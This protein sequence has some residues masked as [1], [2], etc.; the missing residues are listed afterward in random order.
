[1]P[2]IF[3]LDHMDNRWCIKAC[4]QQ[5][6]AALASKLQELSELTWRQIRC[7]P[8]HG[9]GSEKLSWDTIRPAKSEKIPKDA[10]FLAFRFHGLKAMV[11]YRT[12][13]ILQI[14]WIDRDFTLYDHH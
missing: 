14:I 13:R 1:M 9:C 4:D 7:A 3:G 6:R 2:P 8:R 12:G 10:T 11:G 5:D